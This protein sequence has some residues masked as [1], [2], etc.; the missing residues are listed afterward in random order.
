MKWTNRTP[1]IGAKL[2]KSRGD[3][4]QASA[5]KETVSLQGL[6]RSWSKT[7]QAVCQTDKAFDYSI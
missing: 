6:Q 4:P 7:F 1:A 2:S 3:A 5:W